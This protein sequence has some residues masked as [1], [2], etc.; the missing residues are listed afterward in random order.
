MFLKELEGTDE[1]FLYMSG[2]EYQL[3]LLLSYNKK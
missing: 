3:K 2:N 1:Y